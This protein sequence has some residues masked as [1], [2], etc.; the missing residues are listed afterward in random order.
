VAAAA[1]LNKIYQE[2]YLVPLF[3]KN[4]LAR[5]LRNIAVTAISNVVF[6]QRAL[7]AGQY[8]TD[9]RIDPVFGLPVPPVAWSV[10]GIFG[11]W[12]LYLTWSLPT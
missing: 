8:E 4:K 5:P 1:R 7:A 2:K 9:V 12:W 3:T 6:C 11:V 10:A